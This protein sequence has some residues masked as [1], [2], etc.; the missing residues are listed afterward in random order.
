MPTVKVQ[1]K[2]ARA[3]RFL[4]L[5][6]VYFGFKVLEK[7]TGYEESNPFPDEDNVQRTGLIPG[8]EDR[9]YDDFLTSKELDADTLRRDL[10]KRN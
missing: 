4:K 9:L 5:L 10:W 7:N 6:S 2:D 1:Y 8:K 3:L